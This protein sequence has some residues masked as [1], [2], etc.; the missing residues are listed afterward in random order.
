MVHHNSGGSLIKSEE[1]TNYPT[2]IDLQLPDARSKYNKLEPN[3]DNGLPI[4][5]QLPRVNDLPVPASQLQPVE[6]WQQILSKI[7]PSDRQ[8][9]MRLHT[10]QDSGPAV[11]LLQQYSHMQ[12]RLELIKKFKLQEELAAYRNGD[13]FPQ[14]SSRPVETSPSSDVR[15]SSAEVQT[16]HD[17]EKDL[18][19]DD[20]PASVKTEPSPPKIP[21]NLASARNVNEDSGATSNSFTTG[22]SPKTGDVGSSD[23]PTSYG[24]QDS[25]QDSNTSGSSDPETRPR[26]TAGVSVTISSTSPLSRHPNALRSDNGSP[27]G[28]SGTPSSSIISPVLSEK[29]LVGFDSD[30]ELRDVPRGD[31]KYKVAMCSQALPLDL[32]EGGVGM[33]MPQ[34][35]V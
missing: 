9:H 32:R 3:N 7:S 12:E 26:A 29:S 20:E 4:N 25:G 21:E 19:I 16:N 5:L 35:R 31:S 18:I 11:H 22:S 24:R 17:E 10:E 13:R 34:Q 1:I 28:C 8:S 15:P 6:N 14:A 2:A 33:A 30:A 23:S 27:S